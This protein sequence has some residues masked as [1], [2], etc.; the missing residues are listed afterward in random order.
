ML[1]KQKGIS[2]VKRLLTAVV[3]LFFMVNSGQAQDFH[4]SQFYN[5]P[6]T[7]SPGLTGIFH[8]DERFTGSLRDQWRSVTVPWFNFSLGYDRKFYPKRAVRGFFAGGVSF[9]YD[10]QGD[11]SL[12]LN[13][14]NLSGSYTRILNHRNLITLG[15]LV[16]FANRGFDES[17]LTWDRQWDPNSFVFNAGGASG[18]S[19]LYDRY[20]F[21]ET[22]LGLN[23][24]WQKSSRTNLDIGIGGW[25]LTTPKARFNAATTDGQSLPIRLSLYGIYSRELTDKLDLQLD[26]LYQKQTTYNELLFGGYVNLYLNQ[27]RGKEFQLRLGLGYRTRKALYPKIG[28]EFK[29]IF[30]AGSWDIYMDDFTSQHAGAGPELHLR[31]IIKHVK[32]LGKFKNCPI[33]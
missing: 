21:L 10:S 2:Q 22:S 25:H 26:I 16:G 11:A 18:E 30:I 3:S 6:F 7:V 14:I 33:F 5:A 20:S 4:Y 15:G 1:V 17:N 31:Y 28:L 23:Y 19:F 9:N 8:G 12:K 24:R 32:P 13:N 27:D 29:N